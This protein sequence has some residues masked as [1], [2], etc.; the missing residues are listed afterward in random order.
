MHERQTAAIEAEQLI[1]AEV[2]N[3]IRWH[4]SRKAH[5]VIRDYRS[6]MQQI[7]QQ[8]LQRAIQKLSLGK[9]QY[10]VLTEFSERLVNKLT[11]TPTVGLRQAAWENREELLD[12]A[13]YLLDKNPHEKIT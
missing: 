10:S 13:Q 12:L 5:G 1:E 9:C 3:Y 8:E 2:D 6:Q 7:A 4:R 11:H